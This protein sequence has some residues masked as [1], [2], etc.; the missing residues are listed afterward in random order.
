MKHSVFNTV[1]DDPINDEVEFGR[2]TLRLIG[3]VGRTIEFKQTTSDIDVLSNEFN[4]NRDELNTR[5]TINKRPRA[6]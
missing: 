5:T 4:L 1:L 3:S 2:E 6:I